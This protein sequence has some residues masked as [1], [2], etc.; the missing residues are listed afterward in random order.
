M[1]HD[2]LDFQVCAQ[3]GQKIGRESRGYATKIKFEGELHDVAVASLDV[4]YCPDCKTVQLD[5]PARNAVRDVLRAK[6]GLLL[7][8]QIRTKIERLGKQHKEVAEEL[9]VTPETISRWCSGALIQSRKK[10]AKMRAYFERESDAIAKS[11]LVRQSLVS[12][13]FVATNLVRKSVSFVG[14]WTS[15]STAGVE[16]VTTPLFGPEVSVPAPSVAAANS[17]YALAA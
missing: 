4:F 3:C 17:N 14:G 11:A 16:V 12:G 13:Y 5:S 7:P 15:I 8:E 6:L 10:D 1:M 2:S 9:E